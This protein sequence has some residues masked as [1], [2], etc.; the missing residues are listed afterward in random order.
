V[1]SLASVKTAALCTPSAVAVTVT[2]WWPFQLLY[3]VFSVNSRDIFAFRYLFCK[4][5]TANVPVRLPG[6]YGLSLL[7]T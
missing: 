5:L 4:I 6:P 2:P 1:M 7:K 3:M